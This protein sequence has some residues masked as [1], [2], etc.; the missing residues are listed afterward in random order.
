MKGKTQ[1]FSFYVEVFCISHYKGVLLIKIFYI[2]VI[3]H[4]LVYR[5]S[6]LCSKSKSKHSLGIKGIARCPAHQKLCKAIKAL[7]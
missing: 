6:V 3:F 4:W 5:Y 1:L 2:E 7:G